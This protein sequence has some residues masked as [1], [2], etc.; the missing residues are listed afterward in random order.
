MLIFLLQLLEGQNTNARSS[1]GNLVYQGPCERGGSEA[2]NL[3]DEEDMRTGAGPQLVKPVKSLSLVTALKPALCG[4][5]RWAEDWEPWAGCSC[6]RVRHLCRAPVTSL[7]LH[8]AGKLPQAG[9]TLLLF[10]LGPFLPV[11]SDPC[12]SQPPGLAACRATG[13]QPDRVFSSA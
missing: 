4:G 11:P 9:A 10:N 5:T 6:P 1:G 8:R 7:P 3:K 13:A 2:C 12:S